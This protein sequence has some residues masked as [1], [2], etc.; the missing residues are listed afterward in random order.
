LAYEGFGVVLNNRGGF[1]A[2][3]GSAVRGNGGRKWILAVVRHTSSRNSMHGQ[4]QVV[5]MKKKN[6]GSSFFFVK[7]LYNALLHFG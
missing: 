2:T 7:D 1:M 3:S 4:Q 5:G 6:G